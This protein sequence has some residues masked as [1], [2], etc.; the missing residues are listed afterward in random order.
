[1][2]AVEAEGLRKLCEENQLKLGGSDLIQIFCKQCDEKEVCP[3]VLTDEYEA[4]NQDAV[5]QAS[6][7]SKDEA[8][9][10]KETN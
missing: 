2:V 5:A 6:D 4:A 10:T 1:M 8:P 3:S 9:A 7:E